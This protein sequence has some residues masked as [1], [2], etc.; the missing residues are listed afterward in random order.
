MSLAHEEFRNHVGR[1][2]SEANQLINYVGSGTYQSANTTLQQW[3]DTNLTQF[4]G[5]ASP[6]HETDRAL[7]Y[8]ANRHVDN[9][10]A[11]GIY[12]ATAVAASNT[13]A[14]WEAQFTDDDPTFPANYTGSRG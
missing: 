11:M 7:A 10:N 12:D 5:P 8:I 3:K 2:L 14:T 4:Y 13:T 6:V 9:L 1:G